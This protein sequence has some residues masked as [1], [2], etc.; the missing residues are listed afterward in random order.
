MLSPRLKESLDFII[1]CEVGMEHLFERDNCKLVYLGNLSNEQRYRYLYNDKPYVFI[2]SWAH[3]TT[4]ESINTILQYEYSLRI[5]VDTFISPSL[6]ELEVDEN[7][8]FT[9]KGGYIGGTETKTN[10]KRL[11]IELDFKQRGLSDIGSTWFGHSKDVVEIGVKSL[12]IARHLLREEFNEEG[13]WPKW[14]A[15]VI[16]M[17]AGE[18]ALNDSELEINISDKFDAN[19]TLAISVKEIY[20]IHCWHS[21]SFFSKNQYAG[22]EYAERELGSNFGELPEYSFLMTR[23]SE[24]LYDGKSIVKDGVQQYTPKQA[25]I[26]GGYLIWKSLP[27]IPRTLWN[28]I[29]RIFQ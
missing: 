12:E 26:T 22:G 2:N 23:I 8:F 3:F 24:S 5:D 28:R 20:T 13:E 6:I 7:T 1:G 15:P 29:R 27:H 4:E 14:F 25:M 17:Y 19:S 21:N 10:L 16:S 18:L 9:G 11:A